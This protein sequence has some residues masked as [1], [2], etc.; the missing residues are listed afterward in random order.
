[1]TQEQKKSNPSQEAA[2]TQRLIPTVTCDKWQWHLETVSIADYV[3]MLKVQILFCIALYLAN[4][5]ATLQ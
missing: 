1:M 3:C 2:A 4:I 5:D